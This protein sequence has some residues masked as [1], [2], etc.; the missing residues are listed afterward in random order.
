MAVVVTYQ[1]VLDQLQRQLDSLVPQVDAVVIVDNHSIADLSL[2][3]KLSATPAHAVIQLD[4]NYGVARAQNVGIAWAQEQ[5][6]THVLLMDQDSVPAPDMVAMLLEIALNCPSL[7]AVGPRYLD[8]RQD[9][10]PPFL[11]VRGLK[12]E[13]F[14]CEPGRPVVLVDYLISS[15]CLIPT[16]ALEQVGLMREDLFIDYVD[17]EWGLRARREGL[18]CLGVFA[19]TMTHNLGETPCHFMGR[20]IPVHSPLRHYYHVR[21]AILLYREPWVPSNWKLVDGWRLLLK[22]GFYS[23]VTAPRLQ[24]LRL[25]TLGLWHGLK[26]RA[27]P[28][29]PFDLTKVRPL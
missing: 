6:A 4:C 2:W 5:E 28:L 3:M 1:P 17:I 27:G 20:V 10:P 11:R 24:H 22:F 23:L 16:A 25:M 8:L 19:A 15:G 18:Q 21:N 26:G 9:N 7:A 29:K 12:L 13:R 14:A